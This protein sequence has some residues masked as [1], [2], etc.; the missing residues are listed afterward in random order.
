MFQDTMR[1]ERY[2]MNRFPVAST[3]LV[4]VAYVADQ[5]LLELE[6]R[7]GTAYRFFAVP[8]TCF[9]QLL[10]S[11]SKGE[12]FNHNIRNRFHHQR[13]AGRLSPRQKKTK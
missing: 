3:T 1:I 10:A 8:A 6:F 12:Y 11:D 4:S 7:D 2:S 13:L 9:Q 5:A